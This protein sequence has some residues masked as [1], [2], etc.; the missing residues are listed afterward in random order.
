MSVFQSTVHMRP[1]LLSNESENVLKKLNLMAEH[2]TEIF[3][4]LYLFWFYFIINIEIGSLYLLEQLV[5]I[6]NYFNKLTRLAA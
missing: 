1:V 4:F 5:N 3:Q 2:L 6:R